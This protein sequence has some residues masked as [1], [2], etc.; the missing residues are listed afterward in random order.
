MMRK[1]FLLF[2]LCV[3]ISTVHADIYKWTDSSGDVHFSDKPQDGAEKVIL[4]N[5]QSYTPPQPTENQTASSNTTATSDDKT[6]SSSDAAY[7][8]LNIVQPE[9]QQ[10]I[11][12]PKGYISVI[13]EPH[14]KLKQGDGLQIILDGNPIDKPIANTIFALQNIRRGSHT[15][16][17]Q[18]VGKDG[19]V[20]L[21]SD[22][23]TV[24]MMPPRIGMVK[25]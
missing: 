13:L 18:L 19:K 8:K 14:P 16:A 3:S 21:T 9:D 12:N 20:L 4:P 11:R 10:T 7:K 1:G 23:I 6:D 24:Y 22:Q 15:I 5:M 25:G 2:S 17:A